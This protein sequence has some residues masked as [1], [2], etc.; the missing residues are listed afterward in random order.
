MVD[1]NNIVLST[2]VINPVE[3]SLTFTKTLLVYTADS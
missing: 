1:F 2:S 3:K